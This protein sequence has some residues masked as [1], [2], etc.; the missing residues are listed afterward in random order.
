M[1]RRQPIDFQSERKRK[2]FPLKNGCP[3]KPQNTQLTYYERVT[4]LF[5]RGTAPAKWLQ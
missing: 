5:Y 1:S 3:A 2:I 4:T